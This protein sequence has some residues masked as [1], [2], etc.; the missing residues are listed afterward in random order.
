MDR[1]PRLVWDI[2][3]DLLDRVAQIPDP[4]ERLNAL[5]YALTMGRE[6]VGLERSRA[7][8]DA[9]VERTVDAIAAD[10]GIT[11]GSIRAWS[12]EHR[13]RT[14]DSRSFLVPTIDFSMAHVLTIPLLD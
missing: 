8:F 1:S 6:R 13:H 12:A 5:H 2:T 7:A 3:T 11:T 4:T 9:R 10:T 14:G